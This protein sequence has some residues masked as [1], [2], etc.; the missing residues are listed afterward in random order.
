MKRFLLA[1]AMLAVAVPMAFAD[2]RGMVDKPSKY[3]VAETLDR[4]AGVL[5]A[6]GVT[7]F[8]RIDHSGEA[9]KAGLQLRPTQLLIFG[10]PKAGTPLMAAAP[11]LAIDLP[12]KVVAWEDAQ[13]RVWA[14][15]ST[16]EFLAQRHGLTAEQRAPLAA[17]GGLVEQALQ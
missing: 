8:A 1:A 9:S 16:P 12:M 17:V 14:S 7:V 5:Q 13:G 10:N 15:F 4:L 2:G 11:S 6:K 3:S